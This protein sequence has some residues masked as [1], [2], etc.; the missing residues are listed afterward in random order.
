MMVPLTTSTPAVGL[1]LKSTAIITKEASLADEPQSA[2]TRG[3]LLLPP[4]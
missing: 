1:Y 3:G 2:F 4:V